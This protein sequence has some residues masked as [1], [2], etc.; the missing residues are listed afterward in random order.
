MQTVTPRRRS[1]GTAVTASA[2]RRVLVP[3]DLSV[4]SDRVVGRV[5]RLPLDA[6]ARVV[7]CHVVSDMLAPQE[8]PRAARDAQ[9]ALDQEVRHLRERLP[10]T[11]EVE[12]VVASGAASTH[13][14]RHA[15]RIEADLIVMGR[16]S[17]RLLRDAVLGSTAERVIRQAQR[18]VLAVRLAPRAAYR[19]PAIAVELDPSAERT[20]QFALKVLSAPR[21]SIDVVHAFD[22]PFRGLVYPSLPRGAAREMKES[23]RAKAM[24]QLAQTLQQALSRSGLPPAE[25]PG[26]KPCVRAGSP[27]HVVTK[28]VTAVDA[29]L[30][31][32]GTRGYSGAAYAF[33]GSVAGDL[34][35]AVT[36]DVLIVPPDPA[37]LDPTKA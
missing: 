3:L 4:Q 29:D 26:L 6:H 2:F 17:A 10:E 18:P 33:L 13:I 28:L 34:L 37:S 12:S 31:V 36:C 16:G 9:R 20:V 35:R 22:I 24:H 8:Q 1:S 5:L 14:A 30:L 32:A 27:R 15:D 19:R 21:P 23:A 7:L 11:V 25:R